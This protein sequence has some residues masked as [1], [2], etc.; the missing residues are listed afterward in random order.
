MAK[1]NYAK[2]KDDI[3]GYYDLKIGRYSLGLDSW[4]DERMMRDPSGNPDH[5]WCGFN[6]VKAAVAAAYEQGI[7]DGHREEYDQVNETK[8]IEE[9]IEESKRPQV[10][11]ERKYK[12]GEKGQVKYYE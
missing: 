7:D 1:T 12:M 10:A 5:Q 11:K 3:L 4:G 2:K 6:D 9:E 8:E